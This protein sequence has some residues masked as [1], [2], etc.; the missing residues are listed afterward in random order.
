[1]PTTL[2]LN[3]YFT[4]PDPSGEC[5]KS[6]L[7]KTPLTVICGVSLGMSHVLINKFCLLPCDADHSFFLFLALLAPGLLQWYDQSWVMSSY[8]WC[9][10]VAHTYYWQLQ[11]PPLYMVNTL[12]PVVCQCPKFSLAISLDGL[13]S[14]MFPVLGSRVEKACMYFLAGTSLCHLGHHDLPTL[15]CV[16]LRVLVKTT[17]SIS[18]AP[19]LHFTTY[20]CIW[21]WKLI[22]NMGSLL[23][24]QCT[25]HPVKEL[26]TKIPPSSSRHPNMSLSSKINPFFPSLTFHFYSILSYYSHFTN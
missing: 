20:V 6:F 22:I 23:S 17:L 7:L 3:L 16:S 14:T 1:M 11:I 12:R 10:C 26:C 2:Y 15:F 4:V 8:F 21:F 9:V 5:G 18:A 19:L 25:S 13:W 24:C